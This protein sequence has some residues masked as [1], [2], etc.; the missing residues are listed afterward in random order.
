MS[1]KFQLSTLP[2]SGLAS[3]DKHMYIHI[4]IQPGVFFYG[5]RWNAVPKFFIIKTNSARRSR[6]FFSW[7]RYNQPPSPTEFLATLGVTKP[8]FKEK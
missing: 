1:A 4:Y 7:D 5:I 3:L 8:F 6:T 2:T